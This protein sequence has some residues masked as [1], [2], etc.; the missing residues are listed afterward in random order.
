MPL[1][2]RVTELAETRKEQRQQGQQSKEER[3]AVI[4][5]HQR[6]IPLPLAALSRDERNRMVLACTSAL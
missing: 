3:C 2:W 5:R 6:M 4:G 1:H